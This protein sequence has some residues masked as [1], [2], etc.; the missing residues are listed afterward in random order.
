MLNPGDY[1]NIYP[2][3][4]ALKDGIDLNVLSSLRIYDITGFSFFTICWLF[5]MRK[6]VSVVRFFLDRCNFLSK[7]ICYRG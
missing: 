4:P 1:L 6:E 3:R 5:E 7:R 2:E